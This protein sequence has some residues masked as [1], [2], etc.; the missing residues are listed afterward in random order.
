MVVKKMKTAKSFIVEELI[1]EYPVGSRVELVYMDDCQ[2]PA[3]GTKG[4]VVGVDSMGSL[5]VNWDNGSTLSL[6][7][8]IDEYRKVLDEGLKIEGSI[9]ISKKDGGT[10]IVHYYLTQ[11][12]NPNEVAINKGRIKELTL[13]MDAEQILIY[14]SG[15]IL[16][17]NSNEANIAFCIILN[18]YN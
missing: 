9:L 4:T 7:Y 3:P 16:E 2:S 10:R 17:P 11:F 6:L 15:W 1:K 12:E 14:K 5:M 8:G 13:S 18:S